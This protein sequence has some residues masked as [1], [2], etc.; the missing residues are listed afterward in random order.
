MQVLDLA[1]DDLRSINRRLQKRDGDDGETSYEV[2]NIMGSHALACGLTHPIDVTIKGHT[3]YYCA[4]MNMHANI[5]IEGNAGPGVAENMMSGKVHIKGNASQYAGATSHGGLLVIDGD[6]S[7]RCGIS[8]KGC[9]I[10]VKGSIGHLAAFMAQAGHLVVCGDTGADLGDS[11]YEAEIFVKGK[12]ESLGTDCEEKEMND[13]RKAVLADLLERAGAD[14]DPSD[15][16]C[17]G[18]GR[19]LYHFKIDNAGSY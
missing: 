7:S 19:N 15:F 1:K 14:D 5:T 12:V 16:R 13:D 4:G 10:V 2:I 18:S 3:G 6:A 9:D 17:Y 11:I 8:L